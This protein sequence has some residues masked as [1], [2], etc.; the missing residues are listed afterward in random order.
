VSKIIDRL[1]KI[2]RTLNS[3]TIA[4]VAFQKFV[5]VTPIDKGN[6]KRNTVLQNTKI[7]A[8]Y[9]Y[10]DVLDKGRGFRDGQMRGSNQAPNGMTQPTIEYVR[11][12]VF[13][14]TGIRLK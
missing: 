1:N 7:I 11:D 4:N 12:Y 2:T 13:Q 6:A 14:Q 8:N 3:P 9:P 5:D 10:A